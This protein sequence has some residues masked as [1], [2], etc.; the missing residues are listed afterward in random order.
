VAK[1]TFQSIQFYFV[2]IPNHLD[3]N[4]KIVCYSLNSTDTPKIEKKAA[5]YYSKIINKL[6][7][8]KLQK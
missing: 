8:Y 2:A 4:R 3:F 6:R 7:I 5:I 1:N